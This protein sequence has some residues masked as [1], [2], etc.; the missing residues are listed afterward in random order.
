VRTVPLEPFPL[1]ARWTTL[2]RFPM[3]LQ[4]FDPNTNREQ[5]KTVYDQDGYVWQ[6]EEVFEGGKWKR[7]YGFVG[8]HVVEKVAAEE[9]EIVGGGGATTRGAATAP[10]ALPATRP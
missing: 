2:N 9:I 7:Y 3:T 8:H 5:L 10:T 1:K 6:A 4:T